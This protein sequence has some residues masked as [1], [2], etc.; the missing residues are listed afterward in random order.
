MR[1]EVRQRIPLSGRNGQ[2]HG[3]IRL[4]AVHH[5]ACNIWPD[6]GR[7]TS[8]QADERARRMLMAVS[9]QAVF[10]E[11][12]VALSTAIDLINT[13]V[14]EMKSFVLP[15][16]HVHVSYCHIAR[17][18]CRRAERA[19]LRLAEKEPVEDIQG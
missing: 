19:V 4:V 9:M 17:C 8:T 6:L 10:D 18:V 7:D 14:P 2:V 3:L 13:Q 11:D 12:V 5:F 15:G 16:G 1:G